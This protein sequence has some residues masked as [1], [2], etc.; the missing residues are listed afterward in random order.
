MGKSSALNHN[1]GRDA[2]TFYSRGE[3]YVEDEIDAHSLTG[4]R[5][6]HYRR[7]VRGHASASTSLCCSELLSFDPRYLFA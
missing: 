7:R 1:L 5:R 6:R 3:G 2:G 4:H